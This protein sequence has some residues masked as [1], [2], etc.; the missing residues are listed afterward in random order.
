MQYY[1]PGD[2]SFIGDEFIREMLTKEYAGNNENCLSDYS[3]RIFQKISEDGWDNYVKSQME[4]QFYTIK[5]QE[6]SDFDEELLDLL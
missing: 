3:K 2:F 5:F 6:Q 1:P 4:S